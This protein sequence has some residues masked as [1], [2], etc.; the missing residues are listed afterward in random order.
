MEQESA[1]GPPA[2]NWSAGESYEG[3]MG[4]W[5]RP[6]ARAF[7]DWLPFEPGGAWL[8]VGCGTGALTRAICERADPS[9]VLACDPSEAFV[10]FARKELPDPRVSFVVGSAGALPEF[11]ATFDRAVS[12]L[13]LNFVTEPLAALRGVKER[14]RPGGM[15]SVYVWDYGEGMEFL[16][17]FWDEAVAVDPAAAALDEGRRFP[18]CF[19]EPLRA[20]FTEAGLEEVE[21]GSVEIPTRFRDFDD[22]W[23][24]FLR[25]TGP[26]PAFVASLPPEKKDNLRSRLVERLKAEADGSIFLNARA[27]AARGVKS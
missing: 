23:S 21:V 12:G 27:W 20:L 13:V 25:N 6:L 4:R 5:S 16:R 22:F 26:A 24:P 9:S 11:S 15:A 19:P 17:C 8:E 14:L 3:Y 10:G 2:D 1:K 7:L 18:L